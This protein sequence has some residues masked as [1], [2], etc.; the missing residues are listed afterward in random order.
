M[1]AKK[2]QSADQKYKDGSTYK[3]SEGKTY[4]RVSAPGTKRGDSFCAR[5]NNA[6]YKTPKGRARRKAWGCSGDKSK[7]K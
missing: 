1:P 2:K 5:T 3:D 4:K 7:K 6:S